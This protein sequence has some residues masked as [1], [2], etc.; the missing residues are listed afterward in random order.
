MAPIKAS[1]HS[2]LFCSLEAC[3]RE[4]SRECRGEA[5][6]AHATVDFCGSVPRPTGTGFAGAMCG[7]CEL[8]LTKR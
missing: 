2:S 3:S 4:S 6:R 7:D 5:A 1:M 8:V